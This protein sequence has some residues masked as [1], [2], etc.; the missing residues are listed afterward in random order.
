M[1]ETTLE[2]GL[3][4]AWAAITAPGGPAALG[5]RGARLS[6]FLDADGALLQERPD[7]H[8]VPWTAYPVSPE[9]AR[10][11]AAGYDEREVAVVRAVE[12]RQ[13]LTIDQLAR[14][15]YGTPKYARKTL[16]QLYRDRMLARLDPTP[17]WMGRAIGAV[18]CPPWVF[19]LDWNGRWALELP[20]PGK[21]LTPG[22]LKV[23][24]DPATIALPH[25]GTGHLLGINEIWSLFL[26]LA[27]QSCTAGRT[28]LAVG[29]RDEAAAQI[30]YGRR[31][32]EVVQPDA[33]IVL[34]VGLPAWHPEVLA[35]EATR[36]AWQRAELAADDWPTAAQ[37]Q[38]Q[39]QPDAT[40]A[41]VFRTLLL[42]FE[43]GSQHPSAVE[44]KIQGYNTLIGQRAVWEVRFGPRFPRLL[45]VVRTR[46]AILPMVALWRQHFIIQ[47]KPGS[48]AVPVL[49]TSIPDLVAAAGHPEGIRGACW[50]HAMDPDRAP[51]QDLKDA[52]PRRLRLSDALGLADL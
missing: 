23:H 16:P 9:R 4:Q 17:P 5:Q 14:R 31:R 25:Q 48:P 47:P 37:L 52:P 7:D 1:V 27:R 19:H 30:R 33:E 11:L 24:F 18:R 49:V 41:A 44:K 8:Y 40:V 38:A 28:P 50:V 39:V 2:P 43:T 51:D 12:A 32:V 34:R 35:Q 21:P 6:P 29:W 46:D 22:G 13:Y 42:E 10:L 45:V 15:F 3:A 36:P 20:P 26:A